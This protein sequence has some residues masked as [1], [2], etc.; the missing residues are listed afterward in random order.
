[1]WDRGKA[2][3]DE[4]INPSTGNKRAGIG[5]EGS[6]KPEV[7]GRKV[8]DEITKKQN[9]AGQGGGE[10]TA[11]VGTDSGGSAVWDR[12]KLPEARREAPAETA[13]ALETG[14]EHGKGD[15]DIVVGCGKAGG[16]AGGEAREG[17]DSDEGGG[18]GWGRVWDRGK[19]EDSAE[20]DGGARNEGTGGIE[21]SRR[22]AVHRS[23]VWDR[24]KVGVGETGTLG[25][26]S[27]PVCKACTK[28]RREGWEAGGS[29]GLEGV[30]WVWD[31]GKE[32]G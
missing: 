28:V 11:G 17:G 12:G 24:G 20:H 19:A 4:A 23:E 6:S 18:N 2:Y 32:G 30:G 16:K 14:R 21:G 25:R 7:A 3:E 5:S 26:G 27:K 29:G 1:V 8:R 13:T 10:S 31:R 22:L 15:G 9:R